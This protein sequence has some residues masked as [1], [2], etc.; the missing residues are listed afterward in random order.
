[1]NTG[2]INM[3]EGGQ[4]RNED[5]PPGLNQ[6]PSIIII[7]L[8]NPILGDD[9]FGWEVARQL[10]AQYPGMRNPVEIECASLGG[11]SLMER[12]IGHQIAILIDTVHLGQNPLGTLYCLPLEQLPDFSAGHT[13]SS[14]D[15]TLRTAIQ[16]GRSL[17]AS[18]PETI[19]VVGVETLNTYDFSEELSPPVAAA[20]PNA[21]QCILD[22][23]NQF[24]IPAF[25][26]E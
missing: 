17:G 25:E 3:V 15:T 8:G 19:W 7:G 5:F 20:V 2:P 24:W 21:T 12:L 13:A 6:P 16:V 10:E 18:L 1:M 11:L 26:G 14:H 22:L 9:G 4:V 23:L